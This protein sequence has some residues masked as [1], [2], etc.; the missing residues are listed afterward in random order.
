MGTAPELQESLDSAARGAQGGIVGGS[1]QGQELDL[2]ILN[3]KSIH[4]W[5]PKSILSWDP[6]S[7]H[8]QNSKSILSQDPKSILSW[9]PKSLHSLEHKSILSWDPKSNLSQKPESILSQNPKSILS[10]DPKSI[11]FQEFSNPRPCSASNTPG[12]TANPTGA[13]PPGHLGFVQHL[14]WVIIPRAGRMDGGSCACPSGISL[15]ATSET[16][17]R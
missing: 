16:S 8:S 14:A 4:S 12:P 6:K 13:H 1:G 11:L 3:S 10:Q 17:Q 5:D 7:L 15:R 2:M 9:D